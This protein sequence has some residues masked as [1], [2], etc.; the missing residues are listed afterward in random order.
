MSQDV[1]IIRGDIGLYDIPLTADGKDL[2][3]V[4]G[5]ETAVTVSLFSDAREKPGNVPEAFN[6]SGFVG[7]ILTLPEG[8]ELGSTLWSSVSRLT[9]DTR[10]E[11]VDK[12]KLCLKWMTDDIIADTIDVTATQIDSRSA[13]LDIVLFK[14]STIVGR[15]TNIWNLTQQL[16]AG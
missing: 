14:E 1:K 9:L 6:R 11:L 8:F 3:S 13:T 10:N 12:T 7:N 16:I 4:D 5:L 15:Y 2:D